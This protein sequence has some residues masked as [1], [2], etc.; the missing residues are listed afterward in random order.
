MTQAGDN[1]LLIALI[2]PLVFLLWIS[3]HHVLREGAT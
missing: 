3:V 1:T 2:N